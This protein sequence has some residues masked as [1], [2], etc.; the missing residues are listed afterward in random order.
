MSAG[1]IA[2]VSLCVLVCAASLLLPWVGFVGYSSFA[3][4]APQWVWRE[5]LANAELQKFISAMTVIGFVLTG[6]R[7][8][9]LPRGV[10]WSMFFYSLYVLLVVGGAQLHVNPVNP[11]KTAMFV[12]ITWKI[13]LMCMIGI[14]LINTEKKLAILLSCLVVVGSWNAWE[15]NMRYLRQGFIRVNEFYFAGL[16]NNL[17]SISTVPMMSIT[18]AYFFSTTLP[19][20][21]LVSAFVLSLQIHQVMILESRG[22]M[23][24]VLLSGAFAVYFM[25]KNPRTIAAVVAVGIVGA[26]LAGPPVIREF[27][28]IFSK[29][30]ELDSSASSRFQVWKAGAGIMMDNPITGVGPW[31]GEAYTPQ[32]IPGYAERRNYKALHNLFFEVGTGMGIPGIASYMAFFAIPWFMHFRLWRQRR[33]RFSRVLSVAN[34]AALAGIP[35]YWLAS[36][37]SSGALVE[38]SYVMVVAACAALAIA[39]AQ[40]DEEVAQEALEEEAIWQDEEFDAYQDGARRGEPLVV[41]R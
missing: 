15:L 37:F 6:C 7:S 4:L 40:R 32:Y 34:M 19:W 24:G 25:P 11:Q 23:L 31:A 18:L 16:D 38:S 33:H 17:Y 1:A 20:R 30:E 12:D 29:G 26:V 3:I 5:S 36:M 39:H 27:T 9:K 35:G 8:Q 21:Q 14:M 28:T 10:K 41:T 22:T 13:W 2:A